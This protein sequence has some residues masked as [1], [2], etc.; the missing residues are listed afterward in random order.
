MRYFNIFILLFTCSINIF[1][2]DINKLLF[3]FDEQYYYY[4]K[5]EKDI[6]ASWRFTFPPLTENTFGYIDFSAGIGYGIVP[7]Y[8]YIGAAGDG[9]LGFD[10]FALFTDDNKN[11]SNKN[12]NNNK[13]Y[14]IGMSIGGRIFNLVQI[15][16]LRIWSFIGCDFLFVI[17]PMPYVGGELSYK[18]LGVEYAYYL[19]INNENPVR[20][21]ISIKFHLPKKD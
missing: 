5:I 6:N 17:L 13:V 18:L 8:Y 21:Q 9:A 15:H 4:D 20:H 16:N 14:Q 7:G 12:N 3:E 1:S 10:W 2:Q 19:P 11:N